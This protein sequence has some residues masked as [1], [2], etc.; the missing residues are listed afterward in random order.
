MSWANEAGELYV[1]AAAAVAAVD[2]AWR[3]GGGVQLSCVLMRFAMPR[4]TVTILVNAP[5]GVVIVHA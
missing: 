2:A 5:R 4:G 3:I 1:L